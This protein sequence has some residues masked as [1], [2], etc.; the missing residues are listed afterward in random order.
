MDEDYIREREKMRLQKPKHI[1]Q[2]L[3]QAGKSI[4][5]GFTSGIT[6]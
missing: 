5:E 1:G 2:G 6:G 4:F 3:E